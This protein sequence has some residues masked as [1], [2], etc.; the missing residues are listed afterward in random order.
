MSERVFTLEVHP[1][2]P[3]SLARLRELV[4][5]LY[6]SWDRRVRGLFYQIDPECW[7]ASGHNP[8]VFL[9]RVPQEALERAAEDPT[10][11]E[12]YN[13]TLSAY[14]TY[15]EQDTSPEVAPHLDPDQDL[16]AYFCAE[17]GLHESLPLYSG[18]LGILAGDHC[19]AASDLRVPLIAVGLLYRQGY[20]IQSIDH[21]GRQVAHY[22]PT[23]VAQLPAY[24]RQDGDGEELRVAVDFPGRSV[25]LRIW[26]VRAGHVRLYML[27]SDVPE[28]TPEDRSITYQL[29]GG[30][31]EM[32][33][34]QEL[35]L[36]IGGVRALRKLG[37]APTVWHLNEGHSAF[38]LVER[39]REWVAAGVDFVTAMEA[40]AGGS[41]FTTHTPV[42]AGH[43][44]FD[45]EMVREYLGAALGDSG[46]DIDALLALGNGRAEQP[47]FN[48]TSLALRGSR[49]HNGVSRIHGRV[50][51]EMEARIWPDVPAQENP[52]H[53]IT[54]GVHVPTFLAQEWGNLFDQRWPAWRSE[55]SNEA[56]WSV[57]DELP[58][59]RYWSMRQSLKSQMLRD[60][61]ARV[62]ARCKR[63]GMAE[64]MIRRMTRFIRDPEADVLVLGFARRF[65]TYKRALLIFRD[66]ERLK[67]LLNDPE[68]PM[69][70]IFAGKAHPHDEQ[71]QEMI[72]RI[73]ELTLD[74]DLIGRLLL[75][76][77]YDMALARKLV[78]GVDVWLNNP[79]YPLEAC[80]TSGQKAAIN[81]VVNLSVLDG[82]W[83][84][85]YAGDNGWAIYPHAPGFDPEYRDGE[86]ARDLL[87]TLAGEVA[88]LYFDC[89]E[90]GYSAGWVQ[91]SKAS[92]RSTLP[93]FNA[94]RMVMDYVR[95]LYGPAA[96]HHRRLTDE[97]LAGA[98]GLAA[99][100][101]HV[102]ACWDGTALELID[103]APD[104][105]R[106]GEPLR[107]R[108]KAQLN[109][110][111]ADDVTVECRFSPVPH[112]R[113]PGQ[114]QRFVFSPTGGDDDGD[115]L[116]SLD[117]QPRLNGL[118]YFRI[119]M[120]PSHPLLGHPLELGRMRWL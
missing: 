34:K 66:L 15:L 11:L 30:G 117:I 107:L 7:E 13:R 43:D 58:D 61:C 63:N 52:I 31:T 76:E 28:N 3:P 105:L 87:D 102:R 94:Q 49:F 24:P 79:E 33:I 88:P 109:G 19:K 17:F 22:V 25:Q 36:G 80:G 44:I 18:G 56:F 59:H 40:V 85:G 71:G 16:M 55:L 50:A 81:G 106:H 99:W 65:A 116:F 113:D 57:V 84:E 82:W 21:E 75:L 69:I 4:D 86:E 96:R 51:S 2:L 60:V 26:S 103:E 90:R 101:E 29:Y 54:N 95:D 46:L 47:G 67:Q 53:A 48:M 98:A 97:E 108:V 38:Q 14:D 5:D 104:A 27:D 100:K 73:H 9:R 68:R 70:L 41:V 45:P 91:M 74:P 42:A 20:F 10:F 64:A 8:K 62:E 92:M 114:T 12:D 119:C 77:N 23:E 118:Q 32:R 72:R 111:G 83:D 112:P 115:P 1:C 110:L 120:Y 39:C 89:G 6:Y 93:R 37:V 78:T 35:C